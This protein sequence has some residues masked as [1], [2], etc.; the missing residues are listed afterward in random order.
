METNARY[1]LVGFF[2]ISLAAAMTVIILWLS[3]AGVTP[4]KYKTYLVYM[5]ES[6]SGLSK[7]APVKYNGVEVGYVSDMRL[8][9]KNPQEVILELKIDE[10]VPITE[11]TQ[12]ILT[13]QG[14]TGIAYLG[15]QGGYGG[16]PITVLPGNKYPI[17]KSAPSFL[18]R[19][20]KTLEE[21]SSNIDVL[22]LNIK[23]ILSPRNKEAF[24]EILQNLSVATKE[25]PGLI[26]NLE[27]ASNHF[28][29]T[30]K[31][32]KTTMQKF[33]SQVVPEASGTLQSMREASNAFQNLSTELSQDPGMILF[34]KPSPPKG[35]GE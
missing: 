13:Q 32:G 11:T 3:T 5:R 23:D 33:N 9:L 15:L 6:V 21:L 1:A 12:A 27:E 22:A 34:G 4:V 18:M 20:D 10:D 2:V 31:T 24:S 7:E 26:D 30:L 19:L 29:S 17:I 35:P 14:I 28:S 16:K 8:N 25:L